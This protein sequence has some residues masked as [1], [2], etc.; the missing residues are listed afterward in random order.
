MKW[1]PGQ[2][3]H[4]SVQALD[5]HSDCSGCSGRSKGDDDRNR[6]KQTLYE[7]TVRQEETVVWAKVLTGLW[8]RHSCSRE[9]EDVALMLL[10]D[11]PSTEATAL[12]VCEVSAGETPLRHDGQHPSPGLDFGGRGVKCPGRCPAHSPGWRVNGGAGLK[13]ICVRRGRV[14]NWYERNL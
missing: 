3:C 9:S 2:L 14:T 6:G 5:D 13:E 12:Q 4:D 11:C 10:G 8:E 1:C 7:A